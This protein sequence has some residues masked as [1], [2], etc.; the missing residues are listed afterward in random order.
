MEGFLHVISIMYAQPVHV[1]TSTRDFSFTPLVEPIKTIPQR[2][3][4]V[5]NRK[6]SQ[7]KADSLAQPEPAVSICQLQLMTVSIPWFGVGPQGMLAHH[8][9]QSGLRQRI[10]RCL[11]ADGFDELKDG[12]VAI[13]GV[14]KAYSGIPS[15]FEG[16][17]V[18]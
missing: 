16:D 17:V 7:K 11:G 15:A 2:K 1:Q 13:N 12:S 3:R 9:Q 18:K 14:H 10:G 6:I 5:H 8:P 4:R